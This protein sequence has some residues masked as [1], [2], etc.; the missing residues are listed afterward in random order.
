MICLRGDINMTLKKTLSLL[1]AVVLVV[2]AAAFAMADSTDTTTEEAA[3]ADTGD[4]AAEET[5]EATEAETYT[6]DDMMT[7]AMSD[8]YARQAAY[9]VYA[10]AF[11][12]SNSIAS[13]DLDTQIVLLEML[14]KANGVALPDSTT[15]VTA[16]ETKAEVYEAI[17]TAETDAVAMY[18][19][20]LAQESLPEDAQIIFAS[21]LQSVRSTASTFTQKARVAQQEAE[22]QAI[23]E[24]EDTQVY[25]MN[26][27][28]GRG[29]R[30]VY[31]YNS[32]TEDETAA[33]DADETE[34]T[35]AETETTEDT[36]DA[37][38]ATPAT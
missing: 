8:A 6:L 2:S 33:E 3:T 14:L 28:N 18:K 36:T 17:A 1:L 25:V 27:R 9:A 5:A 37:A 7:M 11:P 29:Q 31:V 30:I 20:F 19:S 10:E 24:S 15:D 21:V 38:E 35:D 23:L 32:G 22:W 12:D 34:S 16:P 13:V 26:T 4:A